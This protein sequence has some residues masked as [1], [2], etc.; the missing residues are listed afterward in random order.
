MRVMSGQTAVLLSL[1]AAGIFASV[2]YARDS[3]PELRT[4]S[5]VDLNRYTGVWYEIAKYPNRFERKCA[6]DVSATYTLR[7]DGKIEVVNACTESDGKRRVAKGTAKI[8]DKVSNSKLR[9]TFFWPFYGNYWIIDLD[10]D[11]RW[12]V[13]GDPDRKYLWILSR[14]PQMDDALYREIT[15]RLPEK[16]YDPAKLEKMTQTPQQSSLA[17]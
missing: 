8:A 5:R 10:S 1:A 13:V 15:S 7:P 11:Y 2:A 4:V 3:K 14:T 17:Q 12:V 16:G 6:R 9:V